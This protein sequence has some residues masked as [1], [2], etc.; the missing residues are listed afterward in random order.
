MATS[1]QLPKVSAH[2]SDERFLMFT[3]I[4]SGSRKERDDRK[5][6]IEKRFMKGSGCVCIMFGLCWGRMFAKSSVPYVLSIRSRVN[7]DIGSITTHNHGM[8][9]VTAE[10]GFCVFQSHGLHENVHSALR[11]VF[12]I[13]DMIRNTSAKK[14]VG[15]ET[16]GFGIHA[17]RLL[18]IPN[19]YICFGDPINTASKL[20]EDVLSQ[21]EIGMTYEC[22]E[23]LKRRGMPTNEWE[24]RTFTVSGITIDCYVF[25]R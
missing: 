13:K 8:W 24:P 2:I 19:S 25:K 4:F 21:G 9:N 17:G 1:F 10:G 12:E 18:C 14:K 5:K 20:G 22:F 3:A 11:T 6:Q 16:T 7:A 15:L 23:A